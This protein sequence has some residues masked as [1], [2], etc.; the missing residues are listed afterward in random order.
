[1]RVVVTGATGN[2]GTAVLRALARDEAVD[3]VVGVARRIPDTLGGGVSWHSADVAQTPLETAFDGADAVIHLA[4]AIQPSRDEAALRATNV[5]GSQRVFDAAARVGVKTLVHASSVGAYA[6]GPK[7][8]LIDEGWPATG[9]DSLFYSRHKAEVEAHLDRFARRHPEM[10]VVRLR[11]GLI[12]SRQAAAGIRRL[13]LGP[14]FPAWLANP[15]RIPVVPELER[16]RFQAGHTDDVAEAYRLALHADVEGAFNV[17]A[18]P[19]LDPEVLAD[20]LGARP[21]PVPP[22]ALRFA[23]DASWRLRLQPAPAGW[24]DLALATPLMSTERARTELGWSPERPAT[25]ALLDLLDGIRSGAGYP[26]PPLDPASGGVARWR[27]FAT[28]IG[29]RTSVPPPAP[30]TRR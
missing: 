10:R 18:E 15:D 20:L 13:F 1:M 22:R 26:T 23:A 8:E 21:I 28:G 5:V 24:I 29:G 16:L 30:A 17:G 9:I 19:V 11:P 4:W 27:E 7:H 25:A 14:L 12:F 6:P 2:V 3:S